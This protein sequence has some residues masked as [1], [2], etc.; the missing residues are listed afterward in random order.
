MISTIDKLSKKDKEL[1]AELYTSVFY[2][3]LKRL[4][5]T[6]RQAIGGDLLV[7]DPTNTAVLA[8]LQGQASKCKGLVQELKRN[9]KKISKDEG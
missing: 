8:N 5:E 7:T 6:E 9:H 3:P 4:L 2:A 1:L